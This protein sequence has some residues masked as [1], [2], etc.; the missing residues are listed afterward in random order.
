VDELKELRV[1]IRILED[2]E[3]IKKLK[4][5]YWICIDKKLWNQF[6]DCFTEDAILDVPPVT[7]WEGRNEIVQSNSKILA[8]FITV[9]QGHHVDIEITSETTA[10]ATWAMYDNLQDMR[11]MT[12]EGY[13]FYEDEY[14][15]QNGQWKI[16]RLK[17]TRI[18]VQNQQISQTQPGASGQNVSQ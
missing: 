10:K 13:G 4:A 6:G 5:R 16:K 7:H 15:K 3:A 1:R 2:I 14:V 8:S 11:S 18:F 12:M 17:L 9:H